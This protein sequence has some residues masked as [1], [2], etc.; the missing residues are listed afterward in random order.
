MRLLTPKV[1]GFSCCWA[2]SVTQ[3][4]ARSPKITCRFPFADMQQY[5]FLFSAAKKKKI[6]YGVYGH[7]IEIDRRHRLIDID[8]VNIIEIFQ[9]NNEVKMML[10]QL[11][12][13]LGTAR[14]RIINKKLIRR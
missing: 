3:N 7:Y 9:R 12:Y 5:L 4:T 10:Q 6:V 1:I 8:L 11:S 2:N 14:E 13:M